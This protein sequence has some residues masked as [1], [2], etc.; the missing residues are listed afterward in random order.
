MTDFARQPRMPLLPDVIR[1]ATPEEA[2]AIARLIAAAHTPLPLY[3]WLAPRLA[4]RG[5]I[6]TGYHHTHLTHTMRH[7]TVYAYGTGHLRAVAGWLRP[8]APDLPPDHDDQLHRV[9]G[10]WANQFRNLDH[11]LARRHTTAR[12]L[13]GGSHRLVFLAVHPRHQWHGLGSALLAHYHSKLD[14]RG[15]SVAVDVPDRM[16]QDY[17]ERH[18][19]QPAGK[20]YRV[21]DAPHH[22]W[23]MHRP[24]RAKAQPPAA[25]A[26]SSGNHW[27]MPAVSTPAAPSLSADQPRTLR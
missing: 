27:A 2:D 9:T 20:A 13:S 23:P 6:L 8:D 11:I 5:Q 16:L 25:P 7:G 14:A 17:F 24:P 10:P 15:E 21:T 12:R 22:L 19:Y 26:A 18:G 3:Q 4:T 1:I